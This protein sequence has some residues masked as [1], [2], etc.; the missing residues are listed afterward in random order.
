MGLGWGLGGGGGVGLFTA[1]GGQFPYYRSGISHSTL[2]CCVTNEPLLSHLKSAM[3]L[4]PLGY[5]YLLMMCS[6]FDHGLPHY[7]L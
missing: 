1:R 6:G 2:M 7:Y 3:S 5:S 4:S